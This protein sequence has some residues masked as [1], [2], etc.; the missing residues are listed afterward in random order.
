MEPF[1]DDALTWL[2]KFD[3]SP[4]S[5][6]RLVAEALTGDSPPSDAAYWFQRDAEVIAATVLRQ[7]L[8][9]LL[10][11]WMEEK[12][13]VFTGDLN[14]SLDAWVE[15]PG[16][17]RVGSRTLGERLTRVDK[18]TEPRPVDAEEAERLVFWV[19]DRFGLSEDEARPRAKALA[20]KIRKFGNKGYDVLTDVVA[21]NEQ[22]MIARI[23]DATLE[24]IGRG[25]GVRLRAT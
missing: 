13:H 5:I 6:K 4:G 25:V 7:E 16:D 24:H 23:H 20:E 9:P 8:V 18:G 2:K 10:R 21:E 14:E 15:G 19:E 1:G 12:N 22:E 17:V 3:G 11:K